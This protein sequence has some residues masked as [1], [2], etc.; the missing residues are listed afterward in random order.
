MKTLYIPANGRS[1]QEQ[2]RWPAT[3][4]QLGATHGI[5]NGLHVG[6]SDPFRATKRAVACLL[7][8]SRRSMSE[9]EQILLQHTRDRSAAGNIR[10]VAARTRDVIAPVVQVA[11]LQGRSVVDGLNIQDLGLQ[12]ELGLPTEALLLAK[13]LGAEVGRG[14]YL[15]LLN[16]GIA[17]TGQLRAIEP[18]QLSSIVGEVVARR[19]HIA[20]EE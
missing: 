16:A 18:A 6:G 20:L 14:E 9:I 15:A 19:I 1:H 13:L 11:T 12:L 4:Q 3:L 2:Q 5:I 10:Q 17:D 8:M 7:L